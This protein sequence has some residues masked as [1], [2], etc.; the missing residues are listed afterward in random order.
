MGAG[1]DAEAGAVVAGVVVAPEVAAAAAAGRSP[2]LA[3]AVAG[4]LAVDESAVELVEDCGA[5]DDDELLL[6]MRVEV[7]V[8]RSTI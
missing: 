7:S 3:A 1:A 6:E 8:L 4:T 5:A 2:S